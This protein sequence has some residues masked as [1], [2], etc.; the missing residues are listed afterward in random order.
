MGEL[1]ALTSVHVA[2][3]RL[4]V[5]QLDAFDTHAWAVFHLPRQEWICATCWRSLEGSHARRCI[6]GPR[7]K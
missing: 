2:A 6:G 5:A 4:A 7:M 3:E 1:T